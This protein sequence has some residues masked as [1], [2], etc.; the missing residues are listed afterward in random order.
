MEKRGKMRRAEKTNKRKKGEANEYIYMK[1][2]RK[3]RI[4]QKRR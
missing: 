4:K 3:N 2:K 1:K